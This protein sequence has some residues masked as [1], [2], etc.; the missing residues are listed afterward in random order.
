MDDLWGSYKR[1]TMTLPPMVIGV[2]VKNVNVLSE[3]SPTSVNSVIIV[4]GGNRGG[5]KHGWEGEV[6]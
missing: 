6:F 1:L 3:M 5:Q 4:K 2:K